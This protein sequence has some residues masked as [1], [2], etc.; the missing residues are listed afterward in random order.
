M[1][2]SIQCFFV[3]SIL[4]RATGNSTPS[5]SRPWSHCPVKTVHGI[6]RGTDVCS[7]SGRLCGH[8]PRA[9]MMSSRTQTTQTQTPALTFAGYDR[10]VLNPLIALI[11][12]NSVMLIAMRATMLSRQTTGPYLSSTAVLFSEV[13]KTLISCLFIFTED[14]QGDLREFYSSLRAAAK[15]AYILLPSISIPA[16]LYLL[17][18]N[19]QYTAVANLS[20]AVFQVLYQSKIVTAAIFSVLILKRKLHLQ[21]CVSILLLMFGLV[22]TQIS[23]RGGLSVGVSGPSYHACNAVGFAAVSLSAMTSGLAGVFTEKI[24]KQVNYF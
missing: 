14:A 13:L 5:H 23:Q 7:S 21:Q 15:E 4:S 19:L 1:R 3:L 17:Q 12:Q 2:Y 16:F 20:P 18:N 8:R 24:L 22:V 9:L 6:S 11:L 10:R